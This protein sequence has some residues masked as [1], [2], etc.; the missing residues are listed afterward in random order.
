MR[1][2]LGLEEQAELRTDADGRGLG[3]EEQAELRAGLGLGEQPEL[4]AEPS[5]VRRSGYKFGPS[6]RSASASGMALRLA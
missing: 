6:Q 4:R 2:I 1:A 3:L 5:Y